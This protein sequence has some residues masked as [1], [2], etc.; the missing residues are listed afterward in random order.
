MTS[1]E[2]ILEPL[3]VGTHVW[4]NRVIKAPSSTLFFGPRQQCNDHVIGPYEAMATGGAAAVILGGMLCDDPKMLID[5]ATDDVYPYGYEGYPFG[6]LYDDSFIPGLRKLT[7]AVHAHGCEII[8]Q[9]FQNGAALETK[10]GSWCSSTV[11]EEDLPSPIPSCFPTHGLTLEEIAAFKD[12][13]FAAAERAQKAGFDGI[14]VHA[15]NGYLIASFLTRVWNS[16][17]DQYGPQSFENR[18]RLVRELIEGIRQRCGADFIVGVRMNGQEF[19][20]ERATTIEEATAMAKLIEAAGPDYI[21]VTGYGYGPNPMQYAADFW[22]VPEVL[23]DY[24]PYGDR[25]KEGL[26]V[27]PAAAIK[28]AVSVPVLGVG[29]LT[30]ESAEQL[31]ESNTFDAGLFACGLWADPEIANKLADGH[32]EDI[33]RCNRCGTCEELLAP[34]HGRRCRVNPQFGNEK[35][36]TVE[37]AP[38]AKNVMVIGGG[39]AGMQTAITAARRGHQV[40]LY[41]KESSLATTL[42]VATMVKGTECEKVTYLIDYL[43]AQTKKYSNLTVKLKTTVTPELVK[44]CAPDVL[45][46]A[47]GGRYTVPSIPGIDL[48]IVQTVPS[49]EKLAE[50]PLKLFGPSAL[51]KLSQIALPGI[52]KKCVVLGAQIEGIQGAVF[53]A[54]RGKEVTVLDESEEVAG[55]MPNRFAE[56]DLPWLRD[57]GVEIITGVKLQAVDKKGVMFEEAGVAKRIDADSVLVFMAPEGDLGLY[58]TVKNQAPEV[59]AVGACRGV[60]HS[61]MVNAMAEG[62]EVGSRI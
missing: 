47:T 41:E 58:N 8:T 7:D 27:P 39:V 62:F 51:S 2:K 48:K 38:K 26:M 31:I 9:V 36:L 44:Q 50:K 46:V 5:V 14:E 57:K 17:D 42:S 3:Q 59:Y 25:A 15:A 13:Y 55:R 24:R 35:M 20:H 52:G 33:R 28:R 53:L 37:P 4:R 21:S 23:P 1:Y 18:T 40:T 45:V 22:M 6:G 61:L 54:A 32:P 29:T 34:P 10:G 56:R 16:R 30:S 60:D 12:R 11:A 49:L 43:L 19:G